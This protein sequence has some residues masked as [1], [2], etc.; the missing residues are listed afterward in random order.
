MRSFVG[1]R[2]GHHLFRVFK[3][4]VLHRMNDLGNVEELFLPEK[5][6]RVADIQIHVALRADTRL[7]VY[8]SYDG[9]GVVLIPHVNFLLNSCFHG[10]FVKSPLCFASPCLN[11]AVGYGFTVYKASIPAMMWSFTW[12]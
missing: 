3:E 9:C 11:S 7:N 6:T 2:F 8:A 4:M 5:E 10:N 1:Q 12:Q